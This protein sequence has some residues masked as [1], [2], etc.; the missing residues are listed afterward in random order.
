[1]S[2][3]Y[4]SQNGTAAQ[5]LRG[6]GF[7]CSNPNSPAHWL[8]SSKNTLRLA[9]LPDSHELCSN[10]LAGK[11]GPEALSFAQYC[12]SPI[13]TKSAGTGEALKAPQHSRNALAW[14]TSNLWSTDLAADP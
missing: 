9:P 2:R 13:S 12:S 7:G 4:I 5:F 10:R 11:E 3:S 8:T 6:G 14:S 1:M